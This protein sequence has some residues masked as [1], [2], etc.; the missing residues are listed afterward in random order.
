MVEYWNHNPRVRGSSPFSVMNFVYFSGN[1]SSVVEC[2]IVDQ[3][4]MGSIP[5]NYPL[6]LN[7][8]V[9][10]HWTENPRVVGSIPALSKTL[11]YTFLLCSPYVFRLCLL[12][13]MVDALDLKFSSFRVS[14]QVR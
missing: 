11:G 9:V 3:K 10:E 8:S 2:L 13:E 7:S 6:S 14:V 4:V 5:I 1:Y 12:G